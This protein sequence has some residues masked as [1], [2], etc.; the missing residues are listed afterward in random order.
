MT[1]DENGE[2]RTDANDRKQQEKQKARKGPALLEWISAAVG[3]V[4]TSALVGLILLESL[5]SSAA[6][7]IV[8]IK[9]IS[10][11]HEGTSYV[12]QIEVSNQSGATAAALTVEGQ[13]MRGS[14]SIETSSATLSYLPGNSTRKAGLIFSRDPR[15]FKLELRATGYE[16]P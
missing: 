13:L 3:A 6:T 11:V 15:Q 5:G 9:P 12:M 14:Q 8:S 2:C 1:A 4:I 10:M 7:P 16:A